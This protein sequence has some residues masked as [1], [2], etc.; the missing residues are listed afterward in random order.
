MDDVQDAQVSREIR[1][2]EVAIGVRAMQTLLPRRQS[3]AVVEQ[4]R[5]LIKKRF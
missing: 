5:N 4:E 2:S 3:R 1:E